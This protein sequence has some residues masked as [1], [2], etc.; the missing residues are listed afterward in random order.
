MNNG[1]LPNL[2]G[3]FIA[4]RISPRL[5][6]VISKLGTQEQISVFFTLFVVVEKR[7][8]FSKYPRKFR[9]EWENIPEFKIW[10]TGEGDSAFCKLCKTELRPQLADLKKHALGKKHSE[11]ENVRKHQPNIASK[12][13][14]FDDLPNVKKKR[15]EI[16]V[17]LQTAICSTFCSLDSLGSILEEELGRSGFQM[18]RTKCQALVKNLL[19]P[20]FK[21]ELR[22]DIQEVPFSLLIDE[23]TDEAVSK[24]LGVSI[25]YFSNS[26]KKITSTF[27][28]IIEVRHCDAICLE[29]EIRYA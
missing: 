5:F 8:S 26:A 20:H 7:M 24:L 2:F 11:L 6:L 21:D 17:A 22:T 10:L 28:C 3:P 13:K 19:G 16:R 18:R 15:L 9:K 29:G 27:L 14:K 1:N 23:T 25:K 4:L 12:L